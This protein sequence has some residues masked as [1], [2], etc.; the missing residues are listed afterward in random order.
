MKSPVN[1]HLGVE[2]IDH[3]DGT[4]ELRLAT[5]PEHTNE[6][7]IVHG[8]LTSFLLDGA[9]GRA[10]GR[11]LPEGGACAT[12]QL[13]VQFLAPA[14]GVVSAIG[15]VDKRGRRVAFASAECRRVSDGEVVARAH[16]TWALSLG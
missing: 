6:V 7:G 11:T 10:I 5:G 16:G 2:T 14:R 13:S 12:V 3:A 8:G 4:V 1:E 9:M 15:R